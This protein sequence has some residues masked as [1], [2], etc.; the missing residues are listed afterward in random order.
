MKL[1]LKITSQKMDANEL[2]T[3]YSAGAKFSPDAMS[4][5][6]TSSV[7]DAEYLANVSAVHERPPRTAATLLS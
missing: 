5:S 3:A 2:L 6:N 1:D 4:V 7:N